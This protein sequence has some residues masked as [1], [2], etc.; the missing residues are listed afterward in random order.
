MHVQP[1]GAAGQA[2]EI[3]FNVGVVLSDVG[4]KEEFLKYH[5][6]GNL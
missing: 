6:L 3:S 1:G 5:C 4:F 2:L